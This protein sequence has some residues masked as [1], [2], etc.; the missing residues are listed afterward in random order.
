MTALV[1]EFQDVNLIETWF[2]KVARDEYGSSV[3]LLVIDIISKKV[4]GVSLHDSLARSWKE[5]T[6]NLRGVSSDKLIIAAQMVEEKF[7]RCVDQLIEFYTER[8]RR[9]SPNFRRALA[10][11]TNKYGDA[12][13]TSYYS[14]VSDFCEY[15]A[16]RIDLTALSPEVQHKIMVMFIALRIE[17]SRSSVVT[18]ESIP[19]DG[20]E[21]EVWCAEQIKRQGWE[22]RLTPKSGD[23]GVD[24]VVWRAGITVAVQCKRYTSPIGNAAVQEVHTGR[25]FI[26]ADK[27]IVIGTGGFTNA[28]RSVALVSEVELL[29]ASEILRFSEI[30]G[31]SKEG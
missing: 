8:E 14:E 11:S 23:Q 31:F 18:E 24:L 19:Q 30:F 26:G 3:D 5:K 22:I 6:G 10:L 25:T 9:I 20:F 15:A 28:A 13:F 7:Y 21:F 16:N 1:A 29:E 4:K 17:E 2:F 27:A 12:D